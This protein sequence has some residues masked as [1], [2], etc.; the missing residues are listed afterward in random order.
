MMLRPW[1]LLFGAMWLLHVSPVR[2]EDQPVLAP[3]KD[4]VVTYHLTGSSRRNG[5]DKLQVTYSDHGRVRLDFFR[6]VEAKLPDDSLIFDPPADRVITVL[7]ARRGYLQRDVGNLVNPGAFLNAKMTF[8]RQGKATIA[9]QTCTDWRVSNGTAGNDT[10]CVTDDGVVLRATRDKPAEGSIVAMTVKYGPAPPD[11]FAVPP[12]FRLLVPAEGSAPSQQAKPPQAPVANA[13]PASNAAP[14]GPPPSL[15]TPAP[16]PNLGDA[17]PPSPP[18]PS[19][20]ANSLPAPKAEP[21]G[22]APSRATSVPNSDLA[23][24]KPPPQTQPSPAATAAVALPAPLPGPLQ[25][26]KPDGQPA[27]TLLPLPTRD[28]TVTYRLDGGGPEGAQKLQVTYAQTG[29]R[30]RL[31]YFHWMEAKS[32]F[33][34][35]IFDRPGNRLI[36]VSFE[37]RAILER[38]IGDAANPGAFLKAEMHLTRQGPAKVADTACTVWQIRLP[39]RKD[40]ADTAC[41][42]DDGIVLRLLSVDH[43]RASMTATAVGYAAPAK[44][45]FEPPADFTRQTP[46]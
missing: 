14:P 39:D 37:Q 29:E 9:G 36:Q 11:V 7:P 26:Y 38:Q 6:Y 31:D 17:K 13:P 18:Q 1:L 2:A 45:L 42:T 32:P 12:D 44:G 8:T 15:A 27:E 19:V 21:P 35:V 33:L 40:D 22:P 23:A 41:V 3:T 16:A 5:S 24:T 25:G 28:V 46:R 4:V 10:A 30:T 43:S 20:A 34:A